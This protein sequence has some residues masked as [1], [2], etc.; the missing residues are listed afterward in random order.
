MS[1]ILLIG[2]NGFL[3][4][5][6]A[7]TLLQN[8]NKVFIFDRGI[9][10]VN[11]SIYEIEGN[12]N[13]LD[14]IKSIIMNNKIDILIHLVSSLLP[15]SS[16]EEYLSDLVN[17]QIPT[18]SLL[19]ICSENRIKFIYLS[20]GGTVYGTKNGKLSEI[21]KLEPISYYGLSKVNIEQLIQFHNSKYGLQYLILRPSNPFGHGQRLDGKQGLIAVLIGKIIKKERLTVFGDGTNI[22]DY[23]Y[24]DDF[25]FYVTK[26]IEKN[27]T[28][29]IIN[30]G[31]GVGYSVNQIISKVESIAGTKI[32][33]ERKMNRSDDVKEIVLDIS[34]LNNIIPYEQITIEDGIK[35]FYTQAIN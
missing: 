20:S 22:R 31:S 11:N 26:L 28:N 21:N 19:R 3:G 12:L 1:S 30:I 35:K 15:G 17:V 5:N 9:N 14:K 16:D 24:I 34:V 6:L 23:I 32:E 4:R 7:R 2:G 13:D 8:G 25:V 10:N 29:K 18:V 33:I 27:I